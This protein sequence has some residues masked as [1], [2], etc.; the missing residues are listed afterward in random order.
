MIQVHIQ[1]QK[2]AKIF[3]IYISHSG[4][5]FLAQWERISSENQLSLQQGFEI[6]VSQDGQETT[7]KEDRNMHKTQTNDRN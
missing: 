6:I 5:F 4:I 1:F 7:S 3:R 2:W